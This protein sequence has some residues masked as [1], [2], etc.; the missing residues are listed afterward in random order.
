MSH[1]ETAKETHYCSSLLYVE[2]EEGPDSQ[3]DIIARLGARGLAMYLLPGR[4]C[5]DFGGQ[6]RQ[7][8]ALETFAGRQYSLC[9]QEAMEGLLRA[10]LKSLNISEQIIH[11]PRGC[12]FL[13]L[14]LLILQTIS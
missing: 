10:H 13:C 9:S 14:A 12:L 2:Q 5:R 7:P 1:R 11:V 3:A 4:T 8:K 6:S